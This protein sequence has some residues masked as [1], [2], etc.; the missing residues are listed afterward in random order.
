MTRFLI[1]QAIAESIALRA[2]IGLL[3]GAIAGSF[4][5]TLLIRWPERRSALRGRSRCDMCHKPLRAGELVPVVSFVTLRGLCRHCRAPIDPRHFAVELAGAL[6]GMFAFI[7]HFGWLGLVTAVLG[8]W[9]LLIALLD[10]QHHWLPDRLTLPLIPLAL[11]AAWLGFGPPLV[12]RAIGAAAGYA[13]LWAIAFAY[14]K[15]RKREGMGAGDPKL[16]A[17]IGAW[18]GWMQLPFVLLAAGLI[19]F[20][21]VL[22]MRSRG[23]KVGAADRLPLGTLMA[24]PAWPLWLIVAAHSAGV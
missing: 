20:A 15:W 1:E 13:A 17:A 16:F 10:L 19:G 4:V 24:V 8:W 22:L 23:V 21:A 14:R 2:V 11:G 12:D 5:A 6:I 7:A 3:L 9:L 18:L